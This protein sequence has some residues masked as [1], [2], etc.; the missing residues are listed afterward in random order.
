MGTKTLFFRGNEPA[1]IR[2]TFSSRRKKLGKLKL[3][4]VIKK[5]K[6]KESQWMKDLNHKMSRQIVHFAAE[7]GLRCVRMEDLTSIRYKA[8]AKKEAG[9][10]LHSW[11]HYQLQ[12]FIEYKAKMAGI[13]VKSA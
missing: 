9:R 3:L 7:N 13:Q 5:S 1:F 11:S 2:R 6:N 12:Q 8:K 4:S 10:N